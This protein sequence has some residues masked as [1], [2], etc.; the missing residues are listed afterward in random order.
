M[1][2]LRLSVFF[3]SFMAFGHADPNQR[4]IYGRLP[5]GEAVSQ[6]NLKACEQLL[7]QGAR[8]DGSENGGKTAL[9]LAVYW[10]H[11]AICK[12]LIAHQ[13]PINSADGY[14]ETP[15]HYAAT[16]GNAEICEWLRSHG[17]DPHIVS[18]HAEKPIDIARRLNE[19]D[20]HRAIINCLLRDTSYFENSVI[21]SP[22]R[23]SNDC[24]SFNGTTCHASVGK[25]SWEIKP[26]AFKY[27]KT[28]DVL[29]KEEDESWVCNW[30]QK[31]PS[32]YWI[33]IAPC[34]DFPKGDIWTGSFNIEI[35]FEAPASKLPEYPA[36]ALN[37]QII[38][39]NSERP[40][41][42]ER[43][44]LAQIPHDNW[45]WKLNK[46]ISLSGSTDQLPS[47]L[48]C[49]SLGVSAASRLRNSELKGTIIVKNAKIEVSYSHPE[50]FTQE[51][52]LNLI[53]IALRDDLLICPI[54]NLPYST[55][56]LLKEGVIKGSRTQYP[57]NTIIHVDYVHTCT[58]TPLSVGIL[59][60][61][62]QKAEFVSD[63]SKHALE[64]TGDGPV[65]FKSFN[66]ADHLKKAVFVNP[67]SIRITGFHTRSKNE[68]ENEDDF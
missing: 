41:A 59:F 35:N 26:L 66:S 17:A 24:G 61:D 60:G 7:A 9:H 53:F 68:Q 57:P 15:L 18:R 63:G 13:A 1:H 6:G 43:I 25:I 64:L 8:V 5:L 32:A 29:C 3:V 21:K 33:A 37:L 11:L 31:H 30:Q 36:F 54:S 20:S 40:I 58:G 14:G 47:E 45:S 48:K 4:D 50:I 2:L 34:I 49:V 67:C 55:G 38:S 52:S 10:G 22:T 62:G 65:I 46:Q 23:R 27:F 16:E 19:D 56:C 44:N 42:A 12:L 28:P 51:Q 39:E